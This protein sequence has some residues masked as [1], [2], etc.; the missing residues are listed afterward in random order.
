LKQQI[1]AILIC[2]SLFFIKIY[3][4]TFRKTKMWFYFK[5]PA[6][7]S[8]FWFWS[9]SIRKMIWEFFKKLKHH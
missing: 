4:E 9:S 7:N 6:P 3:T 5:C 1:Q 8:R 2:F